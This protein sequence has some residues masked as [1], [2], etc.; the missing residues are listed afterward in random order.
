MKAI[1]PASI[2]LLTL[3][4]LV[5]ACSKSTDSTANNEESAASTEETKEAPARKHAP[6]PTDWEAA[7]AASK[8][9]GKPILI[10]FTGSDWCG[11]CIRMEKEVFAKKVFQDFAE[12]NLIL[13]EI[14]FPKNEALVAKQ[15]EALKA[16]NE[17]LDKQFKIEGYPTIFLLDAEGEKISGDLGEL[18]GDA[19]E[20][21]KH[22]EGLLPSDDAPA[23]TESEPATPEDA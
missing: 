10:N 12:E 22:L 23:P 21:V 14:D 7:K 3:L 4:A 8:E 11:W 13:L 2:S 9:Q 17:M 20:Y 19:A 15:S 6:W 18:D 16:Q 1:V 5:P